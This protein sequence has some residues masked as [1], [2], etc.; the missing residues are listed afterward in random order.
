[1]V[2]TNGCFD[3]LHLGHVRY[4]AAA[5]AFGDVLIL[6]LNDDESV[7]RLKGP[8]RPLVPLAERAE[9]LA[10]L[11]SVDAVVPFSEDTAEETVRVLRPDV[12]VKG[13]DYA[14]A[15]G[16][17]KPLPEAAIVRAAGGRVEI[18]SFVEGHS[19]TDLI[20]TIRERYCGSPAPR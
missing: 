3:L 5:R 16:A 1:M 13:G 20:A 12:Y 4:L 19:T 9:L 18:V 15:S 7:R 6:A 8:H 2:L 14:G 10:A 11:R 17:G